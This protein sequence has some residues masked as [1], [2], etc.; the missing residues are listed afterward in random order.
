MFVN[1]ASDKLKIMIQTTHLILTRHGETLE[2]RQ[3]IMQGHM[4]GTLSPLG[5]QQANEVIFMVSGIPVKI[6]TSV[7][8]Q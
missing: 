1:F 8:S 3:G 5:I 6:K 2:N 4:P 7:D